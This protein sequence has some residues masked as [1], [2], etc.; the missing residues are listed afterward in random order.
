MILE[1]AEKRIDVAVF[2]LPDAVLF[3]G[4]TLPIHIFEDRYAKMLEDVR[5][6]GWPLAVSLAVP[7]QDQSGRFVLNSICGAGDVQIFREY[8]DGARDV[9]VH[10]QTRVRL[11]SIIQHEPYFVM[12]AEILGSA[13]KSAKAPGFQKRYDEFMALIK[14]W[15][16]INPKLPEHFSLLFDHF[17]S[18][19]E[20]AD[21][22]AFHFLKDPGTKQVFLNCT[23]PIHRAELLSDHLEQDLVRLSRKLF[24][25]KKA[26]MLH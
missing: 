3:P 12:E 2:P 16:F 8:P 7:D 10:G 22:F 26:A 23:D 14:T 20:L 25:Q 21:F 15:A 17:R 1:P 19:G 13:E 24:R 9:L 11:C 4:V 6:R 18:F 5:T